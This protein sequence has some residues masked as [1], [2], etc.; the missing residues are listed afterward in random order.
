[1]P[2]RCYN[3][4]DGILLFA[5]VL[6]VWLRPRRVS[7]HRP[8]VKKGI[9]RRLLEEAGGKCANPGCTNTRAQVHHI[10]EWHIYGTHQPEDM[11][12]VCPSCHDEIH[13]GR[14]G[15]SDETLYAWKKL[16]RVGNSPRTTQ[17]V[18]EP[19]RYVDIL[20]GSMT[21]KTEQSDDKLVAF[22]LSNSNRLGFKVEDTDTLLLN[23]SLQDRQGKLTLKVTDNRVR[24]SNDESI[25]FE[26]RMG[27]VLVTAPICDR[28]ISTH[29]LLAMRE[30]EPDFASGDRIVIL[31]AEVIAPGRI[32]VLGI[33]HEGDKFIVITALGVNFV[34]P[35][36]P[37]AMPMRN[38][39]IQISRF[40]RSVF[41]FT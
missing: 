38:G 36:R 21:L 20:C 6:K 39:T 32:K 10:M 30:V 2:L 18:V 27:R 14:L 29:C 1:M 28:Y 31:D 40:Y 35:G 19:T 25:T 3:S 41:G 9:R 17:L 15:I 8:A 26:H 33:W 12:A 37:R 7:E 5:A 4:G 22:Q 13:H 24:V 16:Q 11:I 34:S 23:V